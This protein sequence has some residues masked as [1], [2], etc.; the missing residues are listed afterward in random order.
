MDCITQYDKICYIIHDIVIITSKIIINNSDVQ[1]T[2]YIH[3]I[4]YLINIK[5]DQGEIIEMIAT[6]IAYLFTHAI[7]YY[8]AYTQISMYYYNI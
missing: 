1:M 2:L 3:V 6:G 5:I 7:F 8:L 4:D